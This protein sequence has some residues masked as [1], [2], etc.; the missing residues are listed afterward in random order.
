M[1]G[2]YFTSTSPQRRASQVQAT[3][4]PLEVLEHSAHCLELALQAVTEGNP[5]SVT[6]A[7]VAG[8]CA[9]AAARGASLNVRINL[10]ALDEEVRRRLLARHDI[11]L[12]LAD[13]LGS[14]VTAAVE[15]ALAG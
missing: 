7:G 15:S 12:D 1:S 9:T 13:R 3:T 11:A 6:D 8:A 5:N 10:P 4:V 2:S 14:E